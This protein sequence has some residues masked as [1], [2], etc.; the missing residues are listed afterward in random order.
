MKDLP[1]LDR[2]GALAGGG[3]VWSCSLTTSYAW[4]GVLGLLSLVPSRCT[5]FLGAYCFPLQLTFSW[6]LQFHFWDFPFLLSSSIVKKIY[7]LKQIGPYVLKKENSL[8]IWCLIHSLRWGRTGLTE[9]H[10]REMSGFK[11]DAKS[12]RAT[13]IQ[14]T[15]DLSTA[16]F[17]VLCSL[18]L[19]TKE[20]RNSSTLRG[21]LYLEFWY[22]F[23]RTLLRWLVTNWNPW[24]GAASEPLHRRTA[25]G[26]YLK[27]RALETTANSKSAE[28]C[29]GRRRHLFHL[30]AKTTNRP[31]CEIFRD[32]MKFSI[33]CNQELSNNEND[34]T[35]APCCLER[36]RVPRPCRDWMTTCQGHLT[37]CSCPWWEV[38]SMAS[39]VMSD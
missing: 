10:G 28:W 38:N 23:E 3:Q 37:A 12:F 14:W 22:K 26:A 33:H 29:W 16:A 19:R 5:R 15:S 35:S 39:E 6:L 25:G 36:Q 17:V 2:W 9:A 21:G 24:Y 31:V 7:S 27:K 4:T 1:A 11:D 32:G 20:D 34:S 30:T 18:G 13:P 8:F